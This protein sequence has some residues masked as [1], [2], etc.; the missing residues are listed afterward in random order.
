MIEE[1]DSKEGP[2][3]VLFRT[4]F[5]PRAAVR[6]A[7]CHQQACQGSTG[8][9]HTQRLLERSW[10]VACPLYLRPS[11]RNGLKT[12]KPLWAV[13]RSWMTVR[14]QGMMC[15]VKELKEGEYERETHFLECE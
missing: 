14:K 15:T 8:L 7:P 10:R 12:D 11:I 3:N 9:C 13:I 2:Q 4:A 1:P 5:P 6:G